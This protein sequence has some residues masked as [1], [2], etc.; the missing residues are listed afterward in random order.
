MTEIKKTKDYSIFNYHES[1]RTIDPANLKRIISS[2]KTLNLLEFRPILVDKQMHII[3]G[4]HRFEAAKQ[5]GLEVYYQVNK[6]ATHEDIVLLNANQKRWTV[7]NYADYYASRGN[8]HYQKLKDFAEKRNL[9]VASTL[10]LVRTGNEH[11]YKKFRYG[12]FKFLEEEEIQ[13]IDDL[14]DKVTKSKETMS[15]YIIANSKCIKSRKLTS[16]LL[17]LLKNPGCDFDTFISK[18]TYKADA[19]KPCSD[20]YAYYCMLRDIYNW[21]NQNPIE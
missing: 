14:L 3:D 8:E 5:L 21:K 13:L 20:T 4:Q 18:L 9:P 16:A 17:Q 12:G 10:T 19:I 7:E 1:N 15:R 6:D 11:S 2:I